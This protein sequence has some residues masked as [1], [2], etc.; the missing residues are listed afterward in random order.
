MRA[1]ESANVTKAATRAASN[2]KKQI[3]F[4]SSYCPTKGKNEAASPGSKPLYA[5]FAVMLH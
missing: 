5:H 1:Q 3:E 4:H 2:P